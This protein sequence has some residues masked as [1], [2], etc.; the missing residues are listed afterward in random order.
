MIIQETH[1]K[2]FKITMSQ[3]SNIAAPI[4]NVVPFEHHNLHKDDAG[5]Y[6]LS[7]YL[8]LLCDCLKEKYSRTDLTEKQRKML[9]KVKNVRQNIIDQTSELNDVI[10]LHNWSTERGDM[11]DQVTH[12][13]AIIRQLFEN[14]IFIC[15]YNLQTAWCNYYD[16]LNE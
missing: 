8:P 12:C 6:A 3:D 4:Y 14:I 1:K 9:D 7:G 5:L 15:N 16:S 2:V 11:S 10:F 13:D